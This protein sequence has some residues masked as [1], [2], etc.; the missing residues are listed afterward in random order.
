M[1]GAEPNSVAATPQ[2][3]NAG[4]AVKLQRMRIRGHLQSLRPPG[5]QDLCGTPDKGGGNP[6]PHIA[7][8]HEQ[9]FQFHGAGDLSPGGEADERAVLFRDQSAALG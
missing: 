9:V 2:S 1:R 8:I 6:A 7:R 3:V 4:G 5:P